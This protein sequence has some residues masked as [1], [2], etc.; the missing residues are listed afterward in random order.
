MA[1][2]LRQLRR[3]ERPRDLRALVEVQLREGGVEVVDFRRDP[4]AAQGL[5]AFWAKLAAERTEARRPGL[6]AYNVFAVS[7]ADLE[8]LQ[9]LQ[10]AYLNEMRTIIARSQ[11]SELV[12]LA[13]FQLFSLGDGE[14][15]AP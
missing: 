13:N 14:T 4:S 7:R 6:F 1:E 5:K 11:P 12:A 9:A 8:R 3:R 2:P 15:P 10:R